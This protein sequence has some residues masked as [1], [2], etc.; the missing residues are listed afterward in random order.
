[1]NEIIIVPLN[2]GS[3][4][5]VIQVETSSLYRFHLLSERDDLQ[6]AMLQNVLFTP[7]KHTKYFA[8]M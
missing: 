6:L 4:W 1:M 5:P 2:D 3:T 8:H 7:G